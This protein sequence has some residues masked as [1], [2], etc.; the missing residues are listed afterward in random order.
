MLVM[1]Q[2]LTLVLRMT[3]LSIERGPPVKENT[4][5]KEETRQTLKK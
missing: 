5:L 3:S 4:L 2:A 1:W